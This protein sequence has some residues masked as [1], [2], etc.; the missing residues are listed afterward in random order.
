MAKRKVPIT[1]EL[2]TQILKDYQRLS[3]LRVSK[4]PDDYPDF[5]NLLTKTE[6][7]ERD[8]AS[9]D[10]VLVLSPVAKS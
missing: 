8:Y 1:T 4:D 7:Y 9:D 6:K 10:V 3:Q 5:L 2:V